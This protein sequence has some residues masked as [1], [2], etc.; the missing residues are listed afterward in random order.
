M[1]SEVTRGQTSR[2]LI[3]QEIER[4]L[5]RYLPADVSKLANL[6]AY[7]FNLSPFTVRY[8]YLP[9]FLDAGVI[10]HGQDGLIHLTEKGKQKQAV[11]QNE[12]TKLSGRCKNCG[13]P[14]AGDLDFCSKEC[15]EQYKRAL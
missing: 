8:T 9:M 7:D 10:E 11:A 6:I 1:M 14:I 2:K 15:M 12:T 5:Q 4:S 3:R 13:V